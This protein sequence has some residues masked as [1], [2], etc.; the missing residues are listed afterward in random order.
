LAQP[1]PLKHYIL[2]LPSVK[3][4]EWDNTNRLRAGLVRPYFTTFVHFPEPDHYVDSMETANELAFHAFFRRKQF[5]S[6]PFQDLALKFHKKPS[7]TI[8]AAL[9]TTE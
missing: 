3:D 7:S 2:C 9:L 8:S 5:A 4:K 1:Q 6:T